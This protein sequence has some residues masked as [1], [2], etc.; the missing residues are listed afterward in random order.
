[1]TTFYDVYETLLHLLVDQTNIEPSQSSYFSSK[2]KRSSSGFSLFLPLPYRNCTQ[3]Q[4]PEFLCS[5]RAN[6]TIELSATDLKII[7]QAAQFLVRHINEVLLGDY[8][9]I[10]VPLQL[11]RI[12]DA[13]VV[14]SKLAKYSVIFETIPNGAIFDGMVV[15]KNV[16]DNFELVG[17]ISR[18]NLY[19]STSKCM[20]SYFLKNYCYCRSFIKEKAKIE[21]NVTASD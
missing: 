10:C 12:S 5:C 6:A 4:I 8:K 18:V 7:N 19:G 13:E 15:R 9:D 21:N 16:T 14:D 20:Q 1:M 17:L 11:K 3:A 2:L